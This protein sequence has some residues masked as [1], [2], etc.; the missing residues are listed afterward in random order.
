MSRCTVQGRKSGAHAL[1]RVRIFS[2]T[3]IGDVE[4]VDSL[5]LSAPSFRVHNAEKHAGGLL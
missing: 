4:I 3:R 5:P 2:R 1:A